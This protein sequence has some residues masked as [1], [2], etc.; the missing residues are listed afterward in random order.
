MSGL[1]FSGPGGVAIRQASA[2]SFFG[3]VKQNQTITEGKY[4][5]VKLNQIIVR[6]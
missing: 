3:N 6:P 4:L 2:I 5:P 1:S